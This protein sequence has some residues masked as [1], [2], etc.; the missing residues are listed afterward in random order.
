MHW[1]ILVLA[2]LCLGRALSAPNPGS[3]RWEFPT[4]D[5]IASSPAIGSDGTVFIGGGDRRIYALDGTSGTNKWEF[6]TNG[7]LYSSPAIGPDGSLVIAG[8]DG[9]IIA[10]NAATGARKWEN[11]VGGVVYSSPAIGAD[12]TVY[13]GCDDQRLDC[14]PAGFGVGQNANCRNGCVVCD[15][16]R[17]VFVVIRQLFGNAGR[18]YGF[19]RLCHWN[20]FRVISNCVSRVSQLWVVNIQHPG[21]SDHQQQH[22]FQLCWWSI[23]GKPSAPVGSVDRAKPCCVHKVCQCRLCKRTE[24]RYGCW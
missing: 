10:L 21:R 17:C 1:R 2:V 3:L 12:G 14:Q 11:R 7:S 16:H 8:G 5:W 24:L 23:C 6:L 9:R 18:R 4:E 22:R 20:P 13:F 15:R 19:F